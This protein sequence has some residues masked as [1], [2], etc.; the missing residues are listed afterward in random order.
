MDDPIIESF[1]YHFPPDL[2]AVLIDTIPKLVKSKELLLSFFRNAGVG[3]SL[4]KPYED[5]LARDRS[6]V[7]MYT[8][9]RELL[10]AINEQGDKGLS[11]RRKILKAVYDFEDFDNCCYENQRNAARGLV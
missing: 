1:S 3:E 7:K 9:T 2:I 11:T 8:V 4:L 6:V 5:L 10:I